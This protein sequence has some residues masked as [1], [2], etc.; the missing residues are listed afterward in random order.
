[1]STLL[2]GRHAFSFT[3]GRFAKHGGAARRCPST[4]TVV[5]GWQRFNHLTQ[6]Q[7]KEGKWTPHVGSGGMLI[8]LHTPH[9]EVTCNK[10]SK[11]RGSTRRWHLTF[12]GSNLNG[13]LIYCIWRHY[14]SPFMLLVWAS[15]NRSNC[16]KQS[17][18]VNSSCWCV[19][20]NTCE[21]CWHGRVP[22]GLITTRGVWGQV[23]GCFHH[24]VISALAPK[25]KGTKHSFHVL[26]SSTS[27]YI[28]L[29]DSFLVLWSQKREKAAACI[30]GGDH[31]HGEGLQMDPHLH[32]PL[33]ISSIIS[34]FIQHSN[35]QLQTGAK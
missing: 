5:D 35:F 14:K 22:P 29:W 32:Y 2:W 13:A 17:R 21:S 23:N 6:P 4:R 30:A 11:A 24:H 16:R 18:L 31:V 25:G 12:Q 9:L 7:L 8:Y 27:S 15:V 20:T 1:M 33:I 10:R 3:G 26:P 19:L 28:S 34:L